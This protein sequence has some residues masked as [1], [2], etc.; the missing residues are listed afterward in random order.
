MAPTFEHSADSLPKTVLGTTRKK[1]IHTVGSVGR[2]KFVSNGNHSF[3][4]VFE[5]ADSG[6]CRFSSAAK[7]SAKGPL[8]PALSLKLLRDGQ[9]SA[10]VVSSYG[11]N[12]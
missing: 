3:T 12:G 7:P 9:P 8:I 5:G 2:C 10:N 6:L 1:Y 11:V 4:G